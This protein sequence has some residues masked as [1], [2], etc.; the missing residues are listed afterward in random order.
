MRKGGPLMWQWILTL[1]LSLAL[2]LGVTGPK[3]HTMAQIKGWVE[4]AR[5]TQ[6]VIRSKGVDAPQGR[7]QYEHSY[8][9]S[10]SKSNAP[11]TW[12]ERERVDAEDWHQ[13]NVGDA[14]EIVRIPGDNHI[15]LRNGVF[16][17]MD[18]LVF[19]IFLFVA[20]ILAALLASFKLLRLHFQERARRV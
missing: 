6:E 18:N 11:T 14:I 3:L 9:V 16:V 20:A 13:M 12:A 1:F 10:W 15:Y 7:R 19:D 2:A 17:S 5:V 8:W 4:G